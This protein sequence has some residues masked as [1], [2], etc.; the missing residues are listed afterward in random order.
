MTS[1]LL[2]PIS[3]VTAIFHKIH[4][5]RRVCKLCSD[6]LHSICISDGL[7]SSTLTFLCQCKS[8]VPDALGRALYHRMPFNVRLSDDTER[9]FPMWAHDRKVYQGL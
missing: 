2:D 5:K 3:L 1:G 7:K 9:L 6:W 4:P 8:D